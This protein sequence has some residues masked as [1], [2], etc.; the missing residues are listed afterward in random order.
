MYVHFVSLL[1]FIGRCH[2]FW[3]IILGFLGFVSSRVWFVSFVPTWWDDYRNSIVITV[4]AIATV[5]HIIK[6]M[7]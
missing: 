5:Q 4:G 2:N 6:G 1:F 7:Y 3:G